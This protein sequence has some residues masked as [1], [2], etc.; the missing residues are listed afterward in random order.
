MTSTPILSERRAG[1]RKKMAAILEAL[2]VDCGAKVE[3]TQGHGPND[4]SLKVVA[5]GGLHLNI[6]LESKPIQPDV[7]VLS[8]HIPGR[9]TAELNNATFGGHVNPHHRQKATYVA[10]GFED[11]CQQL[12][13]GLLMCQDGSAYLPFF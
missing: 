5:V 12:R 9:S 2:I 11:L 8:W 1:D 13:S 3:R 10:H 4:I 7:H 6:E